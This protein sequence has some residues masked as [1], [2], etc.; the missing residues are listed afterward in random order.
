MSYE[1]E[2]LQKVARQDLEVKGLRIFAYGLDG[3][4]PVVLS[5]D[6]SGNL[7]VASPTTCGDGRKIVTTAGDREQF[8][9]QACKYV[10]ITA[11]DDNTEIVV[12]G[13]S[14]VVAAQ[15]TRRGILLE[16]SRS[17]VLQVS[18]LNLLYIDAMVSG[19][20]VVYAWFN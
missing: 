18:N 17:V 10:V 20:G 7:N 1:S 3:V 8:S 9:T 2:I 19:E 12:I 14:T 15:A 6:A 13:G 11:E 4:T 16:P 5:V